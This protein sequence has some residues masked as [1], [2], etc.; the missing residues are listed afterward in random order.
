MYVQIYNYA[1]IHCLTL[2]KEISQ[3]NSISIYDSL[4]RHINA[5][6]KGICVALLF[7]EEKSIRLEVMNC[8]QQVGQNDCGLFSI[9]NALSACLGEDPTTIIGDQ[10][11]MRDHLRKC[12]CQG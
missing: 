9:A 12:F 11:K 4:G 8:H 6:L 3:N 5:H 2:T 10:T 7:S 1:G